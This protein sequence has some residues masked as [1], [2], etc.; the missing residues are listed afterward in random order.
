AGTFTITLEQEDCHTAIEAHLTGS[1]GEAGRRIHLGRSRNDQVILALRLFYRETLLDLGDGITAVAQAFLDFA[2]AHEHVRMPGYTHLRRAMPSSF[3]LWGAAFAEGLLEELE[4]LQGLQRRLDKCPL[5][6]AAGFGA[7][8]A[9]DRVLTAELLGFSAVQRSVVDVQNSRGRH[10]LAILHWLGS[11]AFVVEKALWD[12]S[13]FTTEE[14]GFLSLP[15]AF[16]TGSSIMPQKRNPDVVELLR[17]RMGELRG[18]AHQVEQIAVGLPS[19]YHRDLQLLKKPVFTALG[20]GAEAFGIFAQVIAGLEVNTTKA[21]AACSGDLYAAHAACELAGQG[22]S[23]REAY[24]R[25][26]QLIQSG[27]FTPNREAPMASH[28]GS[29]KDLGLDQTQAELDGQR[30]WLRE[31]RSYWAS[32]ETALFAFGETD[33]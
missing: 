30:A 15:D 28:V 4:A 12:I 8:L 32:K 2:A 16:T 17:G 31:K 22:L 29:A 3:G 26:G 18:L 11:V 7:P 27:D 13:L 5:G 24:Q 9:L 25:V 6:S 1:L 23:F 21:E 19:N 33:D 10:E 14:F 20:R